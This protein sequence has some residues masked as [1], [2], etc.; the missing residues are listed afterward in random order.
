MNCETTQ[1]LVQPYLEG[2]L[3]T[4]ERNEFVHHVTECAACEAEVLAYREIFD[5]LREMPR[6]EAPSR[7][8]VSVLAHLRAEGLA[9]EPRFSV[10]GR[11]SDRFFALPSWIR[12]PSAAFLVIALLYIPVGLLLG[13]ADHSIVELAGT[14]ARS[15]VWVR[16]KVTAFPGVTA[17][18]TYARAVRTVVH[19]TGAVVSPVTWLIIMGV[20]VA[21]LFSVSRILR[22]KRQSGHALFSL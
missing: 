17:L 22:R 11:V 20:V 4:L 21:A 1:N 8:S 15:V 19:A 12:Y 14:L 18:D 2:R 7:L 6:L 16:G 3:A 5:A 10:L 9:H 13:N